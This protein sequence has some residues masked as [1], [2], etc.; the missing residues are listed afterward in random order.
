MRNSES[1]K[2]SMVPVSMGVVRVRFLPGLGVLGS[3]GVYHGNW[4][5]SQLP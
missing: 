2:S 5:D 1:A 3:R 4:A